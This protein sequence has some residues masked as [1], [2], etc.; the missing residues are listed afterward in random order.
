MEST[1][2]YLEGR[3]LIHDIRRD[4]MDA[5]AA[6]V[7]NINYAQRMSD[8]EQS[9]VSANIGIPTSRFTAQKIVALRRSMFD[10]MRRSDAA[11]RSIRSHEARLRRIVHFYM[12]MA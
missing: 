2:D 8:E 10:A 6:F 7:M 12:E 3:I 4:I 5:H 9:C 11:M 1:L